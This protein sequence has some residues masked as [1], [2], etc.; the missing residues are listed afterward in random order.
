MLSWLRNLHTLKL[1]KVGLS[2]VGL[3]HICCL[4]SIEV[5]KLNGNEISGNALHWISNLRNLRALDISANSNIA[6]E[7]LNVLRSLH[8]L[9]RLDISHLSLVDSDISH[10]AELGNLTDLS[11]CGNQLTSASLQHLYKLKNLRHLHLWNNADVD[12][13]AAKTLK[14]VLP[15]CTIKF[16]DLLAKSQVSL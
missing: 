16:G 10:V 7:C 9:E 14:D 2:D 11:I 6:G 15:S 13:D 4:P 8:K 1:E 5:L 3:S 12:E